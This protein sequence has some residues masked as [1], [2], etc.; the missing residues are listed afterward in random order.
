MYMAKATY[1]KEE[2]TLE[3][4]FADRAGDWDMDEMVRNLSAGIGAAIADNVPLDEA[5]QVMDFGA[6]TGLIATQLAP[7]VKSVTAVDTSP[8]MLDQLLAKESASQM[9]EAVCQNIIDQPLGAKFDLIV[10]AMAM[11]HVEDTAKLAQRFA[12]HVKPGGH[13]ALADLDQEDGTFHPETVEDVFHYGFERD[14]L[15]ITFEESG[16]TDIQF[17]DAVSVEKYHKH[18]PVFLMTA[19]RN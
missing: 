17:H 5:M 3:D 19:L 4:K 9:I 16:F 7:R 2:V 13:I 10:S 18:Y 8:A 6:G 15:Q 1:Q 14:Q 11:H 12:E